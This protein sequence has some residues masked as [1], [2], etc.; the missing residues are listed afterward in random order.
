MVLVPRIDEEKKKTA[1][2]INKR[3]LGTSSDSEVEREADVEWVTWHFPPSIQVQ[4]GNSF[5]TY[6]GRS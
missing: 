6:Q 2:K 5:N 1:K 3:Q 4:F